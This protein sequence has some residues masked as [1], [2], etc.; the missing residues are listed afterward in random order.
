MT[1][2]LLIYRRRKQK[3]KRKEI[4]KTKKEEIVKELV[5]KKFWK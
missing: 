1:R 4:R 3:E 2:C 5:P